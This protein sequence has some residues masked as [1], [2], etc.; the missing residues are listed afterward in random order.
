MMKM[1]KKRVLDILLTLAL[2]LG[3]MPGMSMQAYAGN[4]SC[5]LWVGGVEVTEQTISGSGWSYNPDTN[6]LT[7][8]GVDIMTGSGIDV[9]IDY[10]GDQALT[11][12]LSSGSEN[13]IGG[14][15]ADL[16]YGICSRA[17]I[18]FTGEGSL[19]ATGKCGIRAGTVEINGGTVTAAGGDTG[20]VADESITIRDGEIT[21]TG[22][23]NGDGI[24]ALNSIAITAGKVNAAGKSGIF[25]G[26]GLT[27]GEDAS[28][29]AT[30]TDK[31]V[32]GPVINYIPGTGWTNTEGTEGKADIAVS[33]EFRLLSDYNCKKVQF[34]AESR[35]EA[36]SFGGD[37]GDYSTGESASDQPWAGYNAVIGATASNC[38]NSTPE[39]IHNIELACSRIDGIVLQPGETFSFN[40][41]VGAF[42][43]ENGFE[44]APVIPD[45]ETTAVMAGGVSQVA[46]TLYASSLFSLLET[47]ERS[48]HEYAVPFAQTGVDADVGNPAEGGGPDLKFRNSRSE[49]IRIGVR[50]KIDEEKQILEIIVEIRSILA[51]SDYMPILFDNSKSGERD[52]VLY[53][54]VVESTRPGFRILL[55]HKEEC[56][57]DDRGEGIRTLTHRKILNATGMLVLD[58][59]L[60]AK[61]PDGSYDMDTYYF[62]SY[63]E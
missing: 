55:D 26:N 63:Q 22:G 56:F 41:S 11:I 7:L 60:N 25:A 35:L 9:G 31:A 6:T 4:I 42:T 2:V 32:E 29:T 52:G 38:W 16:T 51:D 40:E 1:R 3:L 14:A 18:I 61:L 44:L 19:T 10:Q 53:A 17:G 33:T 45:N 62:Y 30:G 12:A 54:E 39:R 21:A 49:P 8:S 20:I 36:F 28:V 34:P 46:S 57:M 13:R 43:A 15:D 47:I 23:E 58:E 24:F 27:L 59:I 37:G 5:D 50:S 48:N